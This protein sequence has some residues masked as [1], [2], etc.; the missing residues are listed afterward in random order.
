MRKKIMTLIASLTIITTSLHS[1]SC[2]TTW[3]NWKRGDDVE[4][5]FEFKRDDKIISDWQYKKRGND[6]L[7]QAY[8]YAS[9]TLDLDKLNNHYELITVLG[10]IS[11]LKSKNPIDSFWQQA[12]WEG[13][14]YSVN[15]YKNGYFDLI[16]SQLSF[17]LKN[18]KQLINYDLS[19][20]LSEII[21]GFHE[22]KN[23]GVK[24]YD[25]EQDDSQVDSDGKVQDIVN[26]ARVGLKMTAIDIVKSLTSY[27]SYFA[28]RLSKLVNFPKKS[29]DYFVHLLQSLD[30][31]TK[32][33]F[34]NP[35]LKTWIEQK[36]VN[37]KIENNGTFFKN[38][39][40]QYRL[41]QAKFLY[42]ILH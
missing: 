25:L 31:W 21:N 42:D 26:V 27:N 41:F 23:D 35:I 6:I 40:K 12:S 2:S 9:K 33:I 7:M 28:L 32:T 29:F 5:D 10:T 1:I 20:S 13:N 17:S 22:F 36:N 8:D 38:P 11:Q 34:N 24:A 15:D 4:T 18:D 19:S 39:I 3:I 30:L 16:K 14:L 37:F